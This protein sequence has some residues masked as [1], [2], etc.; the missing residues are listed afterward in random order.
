MHLSDSQL[1]E[2]LDGTLAPGMHTA[3][4]RHL[5][6]C[7]ECAARLTA[8]KALFAEIESLP[9]LPMSRSLRPAVLQSI[10]VPGAARPPLPRWLR[11]AA[12]VQ[13]AL[14]AG[15]LAIA[16]PLVSNL[17]AAWRPDMA[18][19]TWELMFMQLQSDWLQLL[20]A[21]EFAVPEL[22]ALPPEF[23]GLVLG[24][25]ALGAFLLWVIGNG[26]LLR[27]GLKTS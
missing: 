27:R 15:A 5:A 14:A 13:A 8:L 20:S 7:A 6:A 4:V 10:G 12:V 16:A 18:L 1:N 24:L 9:E 11:L 26:V 17:L 22:P 25:T 19:L 3:A 23:S 21:P 2:Y